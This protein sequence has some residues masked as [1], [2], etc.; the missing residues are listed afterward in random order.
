MARKK[1]ESPK[2]LAC[3]CGDIA[4]TVKPRGAGWAVYCV[5]PACACHVRG[6]ATETKAIEAWNEEVT[7]E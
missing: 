7:K 2:P 1:K 6:F 5:N 4:A 3:K